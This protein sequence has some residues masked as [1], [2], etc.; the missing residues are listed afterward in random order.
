MKIDCQNGFVAVPRDAVTVNGHYLD[1]LNTAPD[2]YK[3]PFVL[4]FPDGKAAMNEEGRR[5]YVYRDAEEARNDA[6]V[7]FELSRLEFGN[8]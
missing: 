5:P 1:H 3:G 4:L 6:Q 8:R 2:D 7:L